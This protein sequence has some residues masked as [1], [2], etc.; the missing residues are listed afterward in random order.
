M[1]PPRIKITT[2]IADVS[3][4]DFF[5]EREKELVGFCW[6][7]GRVHYQTRRRLAH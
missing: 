7:I 1:F 4:H 2:T 3:F 5:L 6:L